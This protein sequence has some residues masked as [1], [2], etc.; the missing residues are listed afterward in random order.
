MTHFF[1][2]SI[3]VLAFLSAQEPDHGTGKKFIDLLFLSYLKR[4]PQ[5]TQKDSFAFK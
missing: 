1:F 4:R 3:S 5:I 2:V